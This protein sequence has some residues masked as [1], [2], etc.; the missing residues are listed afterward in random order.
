[1]S[2]ARSKADRG[3]DRPHPRSDQRRSGDTAVLSAAAAR[4]IALQQS[5][6]NRAVVARVCVPVVLR[7][8]GKETSAETVKV[9]VSWKRKPPKAYLQDVLDTYPPD[10][11]ADVYARRRGGGQEVS[12]GSGDGSLVVDLDKG[13]KY[14][15]RVA[16]TANDPPAD[17]YTSAKLKKYVAAAEGV[18]V[19]LGYNRWN[20]RF[21]EQSWENAGLDPTKTGEITPTSMFGR[22]VQVNELAEPTVAATN[23]YFEGARLTDTERQEVRDS[24]ASM[25]GY[26]KRTTTSGAYSNHS[27]GCA[28]DINAHGD[29]WQN[30]HFKKDIRGHR[31][32]FSLVEAVVGDAG[33]WQGY[34]PWK[35]RDADRI[36]AASQRFNA[37]FPGYLAGLLDDALGRGWR[38][39]QLPLGADEESD[40]GLM[41]RLLRVMRDATLESGQLVE[42]VTPELLR[43]AAARAKRDGK[44]EV[45]DRLNRIA[46]HWT[47]LRAWVEGIVVYGRKI[48]G[49]AWAY[50]SEHEGKADKPAIKGRL[51]GMVSLHPKLVESLV[52]GGWTWLVDYRHDNQKDFMHFEDRSAQSALKS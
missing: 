36:L 34:D 29:T 9:T 28:V 8:P 16:L 14:D 25:G 19:A 6:G 47:K 48:D 51:Q 5:A 42:I 31:E 33:D 22:S 11:H 1:M 21:Y 7:I 44:T 30:E 27:T 41:D 45:R 12:L 49:K 43:K 10:W 18:T 26:A 13:Q 40:P 35:E 17:Y 24:I 23:A 20:Q 32:V 38:S 50:T 15:L 4:L 46:T 39:Q 3:R 2:T 37:R 52:A